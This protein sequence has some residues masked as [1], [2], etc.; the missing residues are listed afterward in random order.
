MWVVVNNEPFICV[1]CGKSCKEG[2]KNEQGTYLCRNCSNKD[3]EEMLYALA[4]RIAKLETFIFCRREDLFRKGG[5][6]SPQVH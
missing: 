3:F 5:N 2:Y 6:E 1:I 4:T